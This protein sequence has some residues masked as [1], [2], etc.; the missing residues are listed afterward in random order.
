MKDRARCR[1]PETSTFDARR[2]A[3]R[4]ARSGPG[5]RASAARSATGTSCCEPRAWARRS[6]SPGS[7]VGGLHRERF[8]ERRCKAGS[9]AGTRPVRQRPRWVHSSGQPALQ[10]MSSPAIDTA[11]SAGV[12]APMLTPMGIRTRPM[13]SSGSPSDDI[14]RLILA[15]FA[16]LPTP[17]T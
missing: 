3:G 8:R 16:L 4:R 15:A 10:A 17:P 7:D 12:R 2:E 14:A 13:R 5:E 11:I 6:C 1:R 9:S